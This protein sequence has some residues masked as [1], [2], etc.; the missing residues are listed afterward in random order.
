MDF[1][2]YNIIGKITSE[3]SK[4]KYADEAIKAALK[5]L[6][7]ELG[8]DYAVLWHKSEKDNKV[9][10][11]YW[12]T[13]FDLTSISFELGEGIVG[14]SYK[15]HKSIVKLECSNKEKFKP[16]EDAKSM[17]CTPFFTESIGDGCILFISA[18]NKISEDV[19]EVCQIMTLYIENFIKENIGDFSWENRPVIM[20]VR[21]V[22]KDFKNG[23]IITHV[24]KGINFDVFEGEFL[25]F[26][27]ESGCGKS[28]LLNIISGME[29]LTSG[30]FTFKG[31]TLSN[32]NEKEL[33]KY[34]RDNIGFIFQS[35]NLMPN[36]TAKENLDLIGELVKN[37]MDSKELLK[38]V[39]LEDKANNYPSQ[40]S[41][42]QQQRISIAR[43]LVK[44]PALIM[45][46]EPTAALDYE[47]SIEV[48]S[49][50]ENIINKGTTLIMV[51]HNEEI[52][53]MAN[54][55]IRFRDGKVYEVVVNS[56]PA[57]AKD[58]VW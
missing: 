6:V 24:L 41:G 23:E 49:A 51:T 32:C 9:H 1:Q 37:S 7:G 56:K 28:T 27:G 34:R 5:I 12:I 52:A 31:K 11:Y 58:L 44:N 14:V 16:F 48:L 19:A 55:V 18:K 30:S 53:K 3:I 54:R 47:T 4:E 10:P 22:K 29:N 21:D 33:T 38:I 39:N 50:L 2:I 43:A 17:V 35:Y 26:L 20:E 40:L 36:L 46:D 8:I 15:E 13:P 25:C 42:G 57:K 45:A